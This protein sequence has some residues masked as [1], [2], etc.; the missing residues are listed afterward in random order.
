MNMTNEELE[1]EEY[2]QRALLIVRSI[3]QSKR[4]YIDCPNS[5]CA[6]PKGAEIL[7]HGFVRCPKCGE[8]GVAYEQ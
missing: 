5:C 6:N 2:V 8:P 3:L 4:S 1:E 7:D